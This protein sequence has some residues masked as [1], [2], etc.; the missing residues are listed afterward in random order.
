MD[1]ILLNLKREPLKIWFRSAILLTFVVGFGLSSHLRAQAV[2][3]ESE[4]K[5]VGFASGNPAA[6]IEDVAIS[7]AVVLILIFVLAW[8]VKRFAPGAGRMGAKH[9]RVLSSL[10]VGSKERLMLVDVAGTQMVLGVSSEGISCLHVFPEPVISPEKA[11][12]SP[13]QSFSKILQGFTGNR[14]KS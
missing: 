1:A 7:L 6:G 13:D 10:P 9:M 14:E 8:L 4:K 5:G 2:S 11:G 3:D 12:A